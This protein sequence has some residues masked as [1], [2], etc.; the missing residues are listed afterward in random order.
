LRLRARSQDLEGAPRRGAEARSTKSKRIE[1][2][3]GEKQHTLIVDDELDLDR[4]RCPM[5]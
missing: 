1:E 5:T 3:T 2:E 4:T